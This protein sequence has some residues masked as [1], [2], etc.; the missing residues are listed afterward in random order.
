M[1]LHK[2]RGRNRGIDFLIFF[3]HPHG[4]HDHG[5][6]G[7]QDD[8]ADDGGKHDLDQGEAPGA[9]AAAR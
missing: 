1:L 2:A 3:H 5:Q 9:P 7:A 4:H 8:R 6:T